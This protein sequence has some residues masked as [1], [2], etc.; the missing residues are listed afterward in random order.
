MT[1]ASK[2]FESGT[3]IGK[4]ALLISV[5]F[6]SYMNTNTGFLEKEPKKF[7]NECVLIGAGA[8]VP[9]TLIAMSRGVGVFESLSLGFTAFLLF[10]IFNLLAEF[11]GM[12][13]ILSHDAKNASEKL[14]AQAKTLKQYI[15][16][17]GGFFLI[18]MGILAFGLVRDLPGPSSYMVLFVEAFIF[19]ACNAL[20]TVYSLKNRGA[21]NKEIIKAT[22]AMFFVFGF[23]HIALQSGGFYEHLF[24]LPTETVAE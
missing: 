17:V 23:G 2:L 16:G 18:V 24:H 11:S 22:I 19:G 5:L 6:L 12:N 14:Q 10:F 7:L 8:A 15:L 3:I 21:D 4:V 20:A 13:Q 1:V 9:F